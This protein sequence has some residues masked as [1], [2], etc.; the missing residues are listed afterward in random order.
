MTFRPGTFSL[1]ELFWPFSPARAGTS[2]RYNS[3]RTDGGG[4][5]AVFRH[6]MYS[7]VT[8]ALNRWEFNEV[9]MELPFRRPLSAK[10]TASKN[11]DLPHSLLPT[12]IFKWAL[13]S[14]VVSFRQR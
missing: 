12:R 14:T 7:L 2:S 1:S 4:F 9:W 5:G 6:W 10:L 13:R 3:T 11:V 8:P